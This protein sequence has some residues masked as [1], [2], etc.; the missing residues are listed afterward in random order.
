M[1][2]RVYGPLVK[3]MILRLV[4]Q[5]ARRLDLPIIGSGGIHTPNDARDYMDAGA[6]AVQVDSVTWVDPRALE[7]IARDLGGLVLTQPTGA[8][9]DEWHPGIGETEKKGKKS[10]PPDKPILSEDNEEKDT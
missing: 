7:M 8:L 4:G 5:M 2:G 6:R 9:L 3:P 1:S 10:G